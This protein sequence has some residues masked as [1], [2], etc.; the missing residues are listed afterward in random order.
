MTLMPSH[1][2]E[3]PKS[4]LPSRGNRMKSDVASLAVRLKV[5]LV[6]YGSRHEIV[7]R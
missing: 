7:W 6:L 2:R 5:S 1:L 4:C 3:A